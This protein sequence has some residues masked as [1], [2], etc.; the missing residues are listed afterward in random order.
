MILKDGKYG[1]FYSC[2]NFP[3][4]RGSHGAHANG[5]PL[6]YPADYKTKQWRIAA[7]EAFD[8]LWKSGEMT[9]RQ[10]YQKLAEIMNLPSKD[11]H[12]SKFNKAQCSELLDKLQKE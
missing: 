12:I 5:Q 9:R 1:Q 8:Q 4:C 2:V 6:G 11:A 10:A 3:A 7:H